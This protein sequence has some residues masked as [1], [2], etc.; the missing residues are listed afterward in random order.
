MARAKPVAFTVPPFNKSD[1]GGDRLHEDARWKYGRPSA[2]NA[3]YVWVQHFLHHLAPTGL[4]GFVLANGSM[5]SNQS[6]EVEK[7]LSS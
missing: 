6:G 1:W 3:N 5:S 4:A 7:W 2:D